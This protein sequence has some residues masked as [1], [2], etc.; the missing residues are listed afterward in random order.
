[1]GGGKTVKKYVVTLSADERAELEALVSKGKAAARKLTPARMLLKA[2]VAG[3]GPGWPDEQ[4]AEALEVS[5]GTV[6]RLRQLFVE[7]GLASALHPRP[8]PA[9][10]GKLD[11]VVEAHLIALACSEPP[12]GQARWTLRLLADQMVEL[13]YVDTVSY[14]TVRRVLNKNDRKPW[15]QDR[16]CMPPTASGECVAQMEEVRTVYRLPRDPDCPLVCM[17]EASKQLV[18]ETRLP[19]PLRPGDCRHEDDEY[20]REGVANLFVCFAPLEGWRHL[21]V[22]DRRTMLDGA[23]VMRDLVDVHVPQ[24]RTIRLVLDNL[25]THAAG[26]LYEAFPPAEARRILD[27]LELHDTPKH[28][29]WLNMAETELSVLG[30]QCLDRRIPDKQTLAREVAAWEARRNSARTTMHWHFTT[31]DAR[32]K[33]IHLYPTVQVPEQIEP[34]TSAQQS[35]A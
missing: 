16:W 3:R 27:R 11:G 24:A 25:N 6:Q 1:M 21:T 17:D 34:I 2:D 9:R 18:S 33:L 30:R 29:S 12:A 31:A 22:T 7:E 19:L 23:R 15:H 13:A 4:I 10:P 28:G 8:A 35:A 32:I 26:S 14:E 5:T 20:V